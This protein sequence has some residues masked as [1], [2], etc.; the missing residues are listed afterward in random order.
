MTKNNDFR[1]VLNIQVGLNLRDAERC[2]RTSCHI[3]CDCLNSYFDFYSSIARTSSVIGCEGT[4]PPALPRGAH[5]AMMGS[6]SSDP[7]LLR[8]FVRVSFVTLESGVGYDASMYMPHSPTAP[9]SFSLFMRTYP[10]SPQ[11]GPQL[12]FTIQ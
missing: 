1:H 10:F 2:K 4:R 6:A 11:T 8:S 9:C 3:I 7:W 12:F 5:I